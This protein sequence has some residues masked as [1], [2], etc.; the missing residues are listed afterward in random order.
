MGY[1]AIPTGEIFPIGS[2]LRCLTLGRLSWM[3]KSGG[4]S[5]EQCFHL[6]LKRMNLNHE[7]KEEEKT[8][9]RKSKEERR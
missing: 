5:C 4:Q 9:T 1:L 6:N 7:S 8:T 2:W 3:T